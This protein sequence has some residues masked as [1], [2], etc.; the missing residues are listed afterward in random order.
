V[1]PWWYREW[2]DSPLARE[3]QVKGPKRRVLP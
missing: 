3:V 1:N 2:Q